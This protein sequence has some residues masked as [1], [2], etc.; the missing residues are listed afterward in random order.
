MQLD[1]R[2]GA[3]RD[4]PRQ[5]VQRHLR[6]PVQ[7]EFVHLVERLV[8]EPREAAFEHQVAADQGA[9]HVAHGAEF[10]QRHQRAEIA[11]VIVAQRL[12]REPALDLRD[13]V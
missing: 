1:V 11:L 10:A 13:H 8:H 7:R 3:P 9:H 12:A 4:Q 6:E 5:R 2:L